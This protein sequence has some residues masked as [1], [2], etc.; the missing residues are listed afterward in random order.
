MGMS[1]LI[2]TIY[3]FESSATNQNNPTTLEMMICTT[4]HYLDADKVLQFAVLMNYLS[5][6]LIQIKNA[7]TTQSVCQSIK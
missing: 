6:L 5:C 7:L 1:I 3:I 4:L 2:Y